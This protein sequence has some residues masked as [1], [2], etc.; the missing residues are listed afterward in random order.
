MVSLFCSKTINKNK[1]QRCTKAEFNHDIAV[2]TLRKIPAFSQCS[3]K[4]T[5]EGCSAPPFSCPSF[6]FA[7]HL[8][9]FLALSFF[10]LISYCQWYVK[11]TAMV[12]HHKGQSDF[13]YESTIYEFPRH[14]QMIYL[15]IYILHISLRSWRWG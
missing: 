5:M 9:L 2:E 4:S 14:T 1:L 7:E 3:S 13:P 11:A 10:F 6:C 12:M 8:I 15:F